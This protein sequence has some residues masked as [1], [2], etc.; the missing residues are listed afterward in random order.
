MTT[1][2]L[3]EIKSLCGG[4][5]N[6]PVLNE[7]SFEIGQGEIVGVL[8]H[9]GV[10][11][12][13]LIK[14]I[15]GLLPV[16][17]GTIL[18]EGDAI[19]SLQIH[20]RSL[21]GLCYVPQGRGIFPELTA[22]EHLIFGAS[23]LPDK[24][25]NDKRVNEIYRLFPTLKQFA[26]RKG[27]LLSG[28]EKQLL[29]LCR[30]LAA[31]PLLLLLDEPTEGVQPSLNG[32]MAKS[33]RHLRDEKQLG[34]LVVEQNLQF[35]MSICDRILVMDRGTIIHECVAKDE[36]KEAIMALLSKLMAGKSEDKESLLDTPDKQQFKTPTVTLPQQTITHHITKPT[37]LVTDDNANLMA[38]EI[39]TKWVNH[40]GDIPMQVR[41][42]KLQDMRDMANR[43][44]MTLDDSELEEFLEVM[45]PNFEAYD[46]IEQLTDQ[47]PQTRYPRTSGYRPAP[48]E[49]PLN[50]W[51][52]KTDIKGAP[53]GTLAKKKVALKDTICVAGVPM[54]NGASVLQGY[55]PEFDATI[56]TRLLDAGATIAGK[57]TCEY[58]CLSGGS[59]TSATGPVQNPWKM[60]FMAGGSSSGSAALVA[61]QEVELAIAGD[62][63][64]SIRIPASNCGVY[65]MKPTHGLV[66]YSGVFPIEQTIDHVGPVT[67][68]VSDNA[69]M[70]DVL[71][72][73]DGL[74]PRQYNPQISAYSNHV[75]D[76]VHNLRIGI[77]KEGFGRPES[78]SVVDSA[79]QRAA[80]HYTTLGAMVEEVSIPEHLIAP[81][82]WT[83]ITVEGLQDLMMHGN[84]NGTNYKGLYMPSLADFFAGWR[85][86]ADEL[87][88]TLKI[89]MFLGE[90]FQTRYRGKYYAKSQN[91]S[92]HV[93]Q[94]YQNALQK[95]DLLLMPTVPMTAQ[96][97][98][99]HDAPLSLRA[100]R[101][102]EMIGNTCP[103]NLTGLPAMTIPCGMQDGLP[104]G[105]Q[106]V[107]N[108]WQEDVIYKAAGAFEQS[109]DWKTNS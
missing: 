94:A 74:D 77:L 46:V 88:D 82:L 73:A 64:G 72:G 41:R 34:I 26:N 65:G 103:F 44:G 62:Q 13:T 20:E 51:Y 29:A 107:A 98:P 96:P 63:G 31:D 16:R 70:L 89:C 84:A 87:S 50:A 9:N 5:G 95:Y 15:M 25:A 32:E 54:M 36:S 42:P 81:A 108:D 93:K 7:V 2:P 71:A 49:N 37:S 47:P 4:Y 56:V 38:G 40:K 8:G 30:C 105:M 97:I 58:L 79:V 39:H 102:F 10:G 109:Y 6:I 104:I 66:P 99:P 91:I 12:T 45:A 60:G 59:H 106:L 48:S 57:A 35:L 80:N 92:R 27:D 61:A 33:L 28:G 53:N 85:A 52:V 90:Y 83:A 86:R 67:S 24:T 23:Y 43:F 17:S 1:L 101:A 19:T 3:L 76:G 100:Q 18:F 55:V 22:A 68:N 75:N 11:K 14:H 21:K 78:Q 69:L